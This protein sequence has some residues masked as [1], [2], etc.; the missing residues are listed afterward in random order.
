MGG[1][2]AWKI[3]CEYPERFAAVVP[4]SGWG[5]V[6]AACRLKDVP[7]WA[8]HGDADEIVPFIRSKEMIDAIKKCG[9]NPKFTV[10]RGQGHDYCKVAYNDPNLFKLVE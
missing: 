10:C 3:G 2:G 4:I 5:D 7:V 1:F 6:S 8:F 9:G